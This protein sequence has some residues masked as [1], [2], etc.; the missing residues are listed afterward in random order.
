MDFYVAFIPLFLIYCRYVD[1]LLYGIGSII[2]ARKGQKD[3]QQ[4]LYRRMVDED[5][6]ASLLRLF[7][8][9]LHAAPQSIL[10]LMILIQMARQKQPSALQGLF[11]FFF[12]LVKE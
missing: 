5:S 3:R 8:C 2:A 10:H 7:H 11:F 4:F 9:F 1:S 12:N 6:D